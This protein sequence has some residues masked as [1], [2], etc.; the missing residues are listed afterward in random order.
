MKKIY[1][2]LLV[3][4]LSAS[5]FSCSDEFDTRTGQLNTGDLDYTDPSDPELGK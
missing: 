5:I 3:F 2:V 4:G 1:K